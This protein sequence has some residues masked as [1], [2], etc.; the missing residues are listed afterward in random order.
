MN[1][2][3]AMIVE[4][5]IPKDLQLMSKTGVKFPLP[6]I[7]NKESLLIKTLLETVYFKD[8][9]IPLFLPTEVLTCLLDLDKSYDNKKE[10][11]RRWEKNDT[12][13]TTLSYFLMES[14]IKNFD[15]FYREK[16]Y[17]KD[18][19]DIKKLVYGDSSIDI[20]ATDNF[21]HSQI[22]YVDL[23]GTI[24]CDDE[25]DLE[26]AIDISLIKKKS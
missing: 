14:S 1:S 3:E 18:F 11:F 12:C 20:V 22:C 4:S 23:S 2:D 19:N 9:I 10:F 17:L 5:N 6:S 8:N 21:D 24:N 7:V 13:M 16:L 15:A 26:E 25:L